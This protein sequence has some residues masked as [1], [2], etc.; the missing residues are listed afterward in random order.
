MVVKKWFL[1]GPE[2]M[3]F[4][5]GELVEIIGTTDKDPSGLAISTLEEKYIGQV[6]LVISYNEKHMSYNVLI[7]NN[8]DVMDIYEQEMR[9][10]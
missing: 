7:G 4:K 9:L 10:M 8:E 6:G 3:K 1:I 5:P 2:N